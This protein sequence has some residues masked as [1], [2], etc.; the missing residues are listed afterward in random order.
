MA[1]RKLYALLIGINRY[2][3]TVRPLRG[4]VNDVNNVEKM[5]NDL[6]SNSFESLHIQKLLDQDATRDNVINAFQTHLIEQ[7][8]ADDVIYFHFSGHGSQEKA[9]KEFF[10][11]DS[12]DKNETLVCVDSRL[13]GRYDLADKE[14]GVLLHLASQKTKNI[15]M[16][17]DSCHSGTINRGDEIGAF[18]ARFE[19][20][21]PSGRG[22]E[23]Y[24]N[25]YLKE[26]N[27]LKVPP[28][29]GVVFSACEDEERAQEDSRNQCG[30]FTNHFL[31]ALRDS[32][33]EISYSDLYTSVR[34]RIETM[35][36]TQHPQFDF[37]TTTSPHSLFLSDKKNSGQRMAGHS[38]YSDRN[39]WRIG[40]GAAHGLPQ[41]GSEFPIEIYGNENKPVA[42]G[43]ITGISIASSSVQ[44][45]EGTLDN[46]KIYRGMLLNAPV[47]PL[48]VCV[49]DDKVRKILEDELNGNKTPL[50]CFVKFEKANSSA[51]FL[52][53]QNE[54]G[55]FPLK[56][57]K[58]GVLIVTIP[59]AEKVIACLTKIE[60]KTRFANLKNTETTLDANEFVLELVATNA[61][62]QAISYTNPD[63]SLDFQYIN[64]QWRRI[65]VQLKL[66]NKSYEDLHFMLL[67]LSSMY[68]VSVHFD[69]KMP[70]QSGKK[71]VFSKAIT[72]NM[73]EPH[74]NETVDEFLLIVSDE[75]LNKLDFQQAEITQFG[76]DRALEIEKDLN[77]KWLTK[78]ISVK[79]VR[80]QNAI[81]TNSFAL[82]GGKVSVNGHNGLTANVSVNSSGTTRDISGN[83]LDIAT[84][85]ERLARAQGGELIPLANG[86]QTGEAQNILELT[87]IQNAE[88]VTAE[89]PLVLS[90]NAD[91][92]PNEMVL[93]FTFDGEQIIP[94]GFPEKNENGVQSIHIT[95]FPQTSEPTRDIPNAL[96]M[97]FVKIKLPEAQTNQLAWVDYS[98]D[99]AESKI[100]DLA[101]KIAQSN[102]VLL[103]V[104]GI[105]GDTKEMANALRFA[106]EEN[107]Y[108][109][110][111]TYNYE[112]LHTSIEKTA[113]NLKASLQAVGMNAA[114]GKSLTILAH[115]M[116][117][118]VARYMIEKLA[119]NTFVQKLIMAGTPHNGSPFGSLPEYSKWAMM[120]LSLAANLGKDISYIAFF[121]NA[122]NQALKITEKLTVSLEEMRT[123]SLFLNELNKNTNTDVAYLT[124][125]GNVELLKK[126]RKGSFFERLQNKGRQEVSEI[127]SKEPNDMAVLVA[128]ALALPKGITKILAKEVAAFHVTYFDSPIVLQEMED[129][130]R[131]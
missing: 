39:G 54:Q 96:K 103:L 85:M 131:V 122:L 58:T 19:E 28:F 48:S 117:G 128:S 97:A 64:G 11:F 109:L 23:T 35:L 56:Y 61:N 88:N 41:D 94:I 36:D 125:A 91:L 9:P 102:K 101:A 47:M 50:Q 65:P 71:N 32:R 93:P 67:H 76:G 49:P 27:I 107:I 46:N 104:H 16:V 82:N 29:E 115:S 18:E 86:T 80:Q 90:I 33:G 40:A 25:G 74:L 119:A 112:S 121:V 21:N 59:D 57:R 14:V 51:E 106:K 3:G 124:L 92:L 126:D 42:K 6:F 31:K 1:N 24:L 123:N 15:I 118:L 8:T 83:D 84:V 110:V 17:A 77:D 66:E 22:Y 89:N 79:L 78:K 129:F 62:G 70:A 130:M 20:E 113:E 75:K 43:L 26:N 100:T 105:L 120:S 63:V 95:H 116:G 44:I 81:G 55:L 99:N 72:F 7:A 52:I 12:K 10:D 98:G 114:K 111:L 87:N 69:L 37:G 60:C 5:L 73:K 45:T 13:P 34:S 53:E 68:G 2:L 108:D 127:L 38:V 4:C 30:L